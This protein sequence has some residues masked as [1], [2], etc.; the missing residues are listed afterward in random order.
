[1]SHRVEHLLVVHFVFLS[2]LGVFGRMGAALCLDIVSDPRS[3]I[4]M[5]GQSQIGQVTWLR[6]SDLSGDAMAFFANE[7]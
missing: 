3:K 7:K 4:K 6:L 5:S 1:M 2:W